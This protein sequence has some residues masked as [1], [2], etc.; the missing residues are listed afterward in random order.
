MLRSKRAVALLV[1]CSSIAI[2][3]GMGAAA[4]AVT[5]KTITFLDV[6]DSGHGKYYFMSHVLIPDFEKK[7]PNIHVNL[8]SVPFNEFDPKLS[9]LVA[10]GNPPDVWSSWGP[11][12]LMDYKNRGLIA[13]LTPYIK[14]THW[15]NPNIP[16]RLFDTYKFNG[17]QY[18]IPVAFFP[19]FIVYNKTLF[20]Q[21]HVPFPNYKWGDKKWNWQAMVSTAKKLTKNY[22][23][24]EAT[25]GLNWALG[26]PDSYGWEFGIDL[27][28]NKNV[29]KTGY[30]TGNNFANPKYIAAIQA[31][32]NL[33]YKDKVSPT[34]AVSQAIAGTGDA[35][36][37][38]KIA[39]EA[40][41]GLLLGQAKQTGMK[42]GVA[43]IPVGPTGLSPSILYTAPMMMSAKTQHPNSAMKFIEF[44]ASPEGQ[45]L[46]VQTTGFPPADQ[47]AAQIWFHSFASNGL[48]ASQLQYMTD[49]SIA[50]GKESPNHT[51]TGYA[52]IATFLTNN[53]QPIFTEDQSPAKVLPALVQPFNQ[54]LQQIRQQTQHH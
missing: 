38:G 39:M 19:S 43:P 27:Y 25:Y 17:E 8:I 4:S 16:G 24:P 15:S 11:S 20:Q 44:F 32:Q 33:I 53:L 6:T 12:G 30:A 54:L 31:Y 49:E 14:K 34:P 40:N 28:T 9:A 22:G 10:S 48:S 42:F 45:K 37:T 46:W 3:A 5:T 2:T 26:N 52:Q 47:K 36:L 1:A 35:F 7:Y 51:V 23:Q 18:A 41:I 13:N 21:D 50:H 29:Y